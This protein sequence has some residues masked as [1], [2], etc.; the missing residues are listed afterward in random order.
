MLRFDRSI[1]A[2]VKRDLRPQFASAIILSIESSPVVVYVAVGGPGVDAISAKEQR[3]LVAD[4]ARRL[5]IS[6]EPK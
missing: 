2:D 6:E 5:R 3:A 1:E 4:I